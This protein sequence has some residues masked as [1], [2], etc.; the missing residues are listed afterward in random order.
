MSNI[1][2]SPKAEAP[3]EIKHVFIVRL[4]CEPQE[5]VDTLPEWRALIE[6]VN[7]GKRY[8]VDDINAIFSLLAPHWDDLGVGGPPTNCKPLP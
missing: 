4:W 8:V 7:S 6:H 3:D 5:R 2:I 1:N